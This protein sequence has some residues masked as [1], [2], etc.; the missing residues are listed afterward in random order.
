MLKDDDSNDRKISFDG[1]SLFPF[2]FKSVISS[3]LDLG[4]NN[5]F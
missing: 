5:R 4:S 2:N 1:F 3:Q